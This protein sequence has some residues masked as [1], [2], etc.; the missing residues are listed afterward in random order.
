MSGPHVSPS[1][2]VHDQ[3]VR[4]HQRHCAG[5]RTHQAWLREH[6]SLDNPALSVTHCPCGHAEMLLCATCGAVLFVRHDRGLPL[7]E[8]ARWAL[9]EFGC[10]EVP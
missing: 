3:H 9:V 8:H 5:I 6:V 4:E 2:E 10:G 7:C 1:A